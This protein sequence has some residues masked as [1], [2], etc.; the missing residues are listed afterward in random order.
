M[1]KIILERLER[2]RV[3]RCK[4]KRKKEIYAKAS[5]TVKI[6]A[7]TTRKR[8]A[9]FKNELRFLQDKTLSCKNFIRYKIYLNVLL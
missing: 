3:K 2:K 8:A 6:V 4:F 5:V 9:S 1:S 7:S